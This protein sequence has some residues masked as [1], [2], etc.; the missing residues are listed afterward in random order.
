MSH[1]ARGFDTLA[2]ARLLH[3]R[4]QGQRCR[5]AP[6]PCKISNCGINPVYHLLYKEQLP[7][8]HRA[9]GSCSLISLT[10]PFCYRGGLYRTRKFT[11][12]N[13]TQKHNYNTMAKKKYQ[14]HR[15]RKNLVIAYMAESTAPTPATTST[16]H[17][18]TR[19]TIF[20]SARFSPQYSRQ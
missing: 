19:K 11:N 12:K 13:N 20:R 4:Q 14:R 18:P 2:A 8:S 1:S 9:D 10:Q 7:P 15:N 6:Q 3:C 17:R 5:P 16:H